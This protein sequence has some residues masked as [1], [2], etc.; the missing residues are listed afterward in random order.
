[1]NGLLARSVRAPLPFLLAVLGTLAISIGASSAMFTVVNAFLLSSLPYEGADRLAVVWRTPLEHATSESAE[2]I[3]LSPGAF[4]DLRESADSFES[5]GGLISDWAIVSDGDVPQRVRLMAVLGDF[6]QLMRTQ[7]A[8]GRTLGQEDARPDAAPVVVISYGFWQRQLAGDPGVLGRGLMIGGEETTV[9]GVLPDDFRLVDSLIAGDPRFSQPVD[10]W[11]PF[12]LG[13]SAY[14]RGSHFVYAVGRLASSVSVEAAQREMDAHARAAAE[15]FPDTERG[16]GVEVVALRDEIFGH[17]RPA[18]LTLLAATGLVLLIACANLATLFLTRA[19]TSYRDIAVRMALGADRRTIVRESLLG[20][21]LLA[22]SGGVLALLVAYGVAETLTKLAPLRVFN[23]Y[24]PQVDF[25]VVIY[26]LAVSTLAGILFGGLP[27]YWASRIQIATGLRERIAQVTLRSRWV[28]ASFVVLQIALATTLL[29]ATGLSIRTYVKLLDADLGVDVRGIATFDLY[30]SRSQHRDQVSLAASFRDLH[31]RISALPGVE[32]V[33][34]NYALPFSGV[35][36]SNGFTIEGRP[37]RQGES[38]SANLGLVNPEYFATLGIP[39]LRGR[40]FRSTDGTDAAPVAIIDEHMA[41]RYF[42]DRDPLGRRLSIASDEMATIVGV[43]GAVQQKAVE[44]RGLPYVYLPIEQRSTL[45][46]SFAVKTNLDDPL[47][48]VDQVRRVVAELGV[49]ISNVST[50][51]QAYANAIAPQRF[52]LLLITSLAGIA[53][54]LALVGVYV[55][56][57]FVADQR[58]REVGIR[59]AVGADAMRIF[60]LFAREGLTLSLVGTAIGLA[61]GIGVERFLASLV[62]GVGPLDPVVFGLVPLAILLTAF[63]AYAVPARSMTR[64][65]PS[66]VLRPT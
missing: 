8:L 14:Q 13:Q 17:L 47:A 63:L 38:L 28:F 11:V 9:V 18:L 55:V 1:M 42:G 32:S 58:R 65:E 52:N 12:D 4:T 51:E 49:P 23:S 10:L 20:S 57:S 50:L 62:Y 40:L 21:V 45:S 43:V 44:D 59:M 31:A 48:V 15:E 16:Y 5:V 35:D 56:M 27:A 60:W 7:A 64:I 19:R 22:L 33:G 54:F 34:V 6:F 2:R 26:T 37:S 61:L 41:A 29:L 46:A 24:P 66:T 3:P 39:L 25:A 53:L 30:L 36:P